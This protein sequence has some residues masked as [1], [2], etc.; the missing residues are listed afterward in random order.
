MKERYT[1]MSLHVQINDKK[2]K[3]MFVS[4]IQLLK[5]CS[6]SI[7]MRFETT[8]LH[9]QGMD[10][11]HICLFDVVLRKDWFSTYETT[12]S[13]IEICVDTSVFYAIISIKT[14][15][16][17]IVMRMTDKNADVLYV[18][19]QLEDATNI[20]KSVKMP[21]MVYDYEELSIPT[22]EYDADFSLPSKQFAEM[23]AQ[24]GDFGNNMRL[25]C[26]EKNISMKTVGSD[27]E[28]T[29]DIPMELLTSYGIIQGE[30]ISLVY[31]LEHI[32][33]MCITSKLSNEIEIYISNERPMKILYSL[34]ADS[35]DDN[36]PGDYVTFYI[37]PRF[38]DDL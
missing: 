2:K 1:T 22:V 21:L 35:N 19:F 11:S 15:Q 38:D 3:E 23:F 37:A 33:K 16:S 28:L 30:T 32:N 27:S 25:V 20:K 36:S 7:H 12:D 29:I 13:P 24:L 4:L 10:K 8:R 6:S 14:E 5:N 26:T 17:V 18:Q 31:S 34:S 9:I